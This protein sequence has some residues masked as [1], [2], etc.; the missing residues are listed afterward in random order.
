[1]AALSWAAF[2]LLW[3]QVLVLPNPLVPPRVFVELLGEV[4]AATNP[5]R[6][7][8]MVIKETSLL[9]CGFALIGFAL[10]ILARRVEARRSAFVAASLCTITVAISLVPVAQA[11]RTASAEGGSLSPFG[12]FEGPSS[13][14]D[15]SPR[16]ATYA[17]R[18][19]GVD[20][21]LDIWKPSGEAGRDLGQDP[22]AEGDAAERRPAVIV[23]HGGG[24]H[25]G[26]R[27]EFPRWN[28]WLADR[29]YVVFD[30][31]YRLTPPPRWQ[32]A[33]AD[34]RCAVGW[35]KENADRYGVDRERVGL[36]GRSA[37]GQLALLTAYTPGAPT[38]PGA[39]TFAKPQTRAW[40]RWRRFIRPP[41]F[42]ASPAS[43]TWTGWSASWVAPRVPCP[44]A[45]ASPRPSPTWGPA[46]HRLSSST[47]AT[48]A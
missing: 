39:A 18:P 8:V 12:H 40:R 2:G 5:Q 41:T 36:L 28:A 11:W 34:V 6:F 23:V 26:Q 20:L 44:D 37:G 19:G 35:V 25:S 29:G 13:A 16:T 3:A 22:G 4:P 7:A 42:P 27:G 9:L 45:T 10:A 43:A 24:W 31:D 1:M 21:K 32:D 33:P 47:G 46:T 30:V 48:T 38:L 14:A 15:G 17:V